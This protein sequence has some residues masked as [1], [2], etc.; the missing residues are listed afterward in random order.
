MFAYRYNAR[1]TPEGR[2]RRLLALALGLAVPTALV[3]GSIVAASARTTR[4]GRHRPPVASTPAATGSASAAA[5]GSTPTASA[6]A[7][8]VA[9]SNPNCALIVP[10]DPLSAVG[11]ATPYRLVAAN[12]ADG[13]CHESD[14]AQAAFVQATVVDPATGAVAN[15]NPL[16]IDQNSTP[17]A[18]PTVPT[19]PAGA[20]VG[21][22]FGYNGDTLT[23]RGTSGTSL[24]AGTCVNGLNGSLFGQYAYCNA[25]AFFQAAN[26]AITAGKLA[27]P[28]LGTGSD[29]LPCPTTRDFGIVDQDQSDNLTATYLVAGTNGMA[30]NTAANRTKLGGAT[31]LSNGSDNG[32]VASILDPLLGCTPWKAP[33]LADP[34]AT[35]SSLALNELLAAARQAAPVALVPVNDPMVLV[36]GAA[37][38]A[39]TDLYRVGVNMP[40]VNT[41]TETPQAY[42]QNM[43][44][45]G[46]SR[47]FKDRTLTRAAP[48]PDPAAANSLFTF[49]AQRLQQSFI[50]LNCTR[51]TGRRPPVRVG[52]AAN[53]VAI[54][55]VPDTTASP[56]PQPTD[57]TSPT[58]PASPAPS[59]TAPET[60]LPT[61]TQHF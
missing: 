50:N 30:Q 51:N 57:G 43:A 28:A 24:S 47:L 32:L 3:A 31:P 8:P 61:S 26:A 10:D 41:A 59:L 48:S 18:A 40:A 33:D 5:S 14:K 6:S 53:G 17:A 56:T 58:A 34:G 52:R 49:L 21:I 13:A 60:P 29:G 7:T 9:T 54:E 23:L 11:L 44:T 16:V 38:V 22:W 46:M 45:A 2:P 25:V 36:N 4:Q 27:V 20:V 15:Y 42:C 37:S 39:K 1:P 19:L 35:T 12:P 55:A